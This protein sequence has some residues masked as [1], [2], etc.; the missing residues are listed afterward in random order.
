MLWPTHPRVERAVISGV[1]E[2]GGLLRASPAGGLER[3]IRRQGGVN[4]AGAN[5]VSEFVI[6]RY[7]D[8][9]SRAR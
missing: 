2:A 1:F 6:V 3:Y 9:V 7:H 5:P 8:A 4:D